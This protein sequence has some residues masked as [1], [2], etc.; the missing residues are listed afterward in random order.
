MFNISFSLQL[1]P[2]GPING[3]K[4]LLFSEEGQA[5]ITEWLVS[6]WYIIA[7]AFL[8]FIILLVSSL[9]S[10]LHRKCYFKFRLA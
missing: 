4:N 9:H 1:D 7:S 5:S 2:V 10:R 3:L 8:G 6:N